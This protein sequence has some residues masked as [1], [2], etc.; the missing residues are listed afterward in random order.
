MEGSLLASWA[1]GWLCSFSW[2]ASTD[3]GVCTLG[4]PWECI[5]EH[6]PSAE[7]L[8]SYIIIATVRKL[9]TSGGWRVAKGVWACSVKV[10]VGWLSG[11]QKVS[12]NGDKVLCHSQLS[13]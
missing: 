1:T 9:G 12:G 10:S 3:F 4:L 7:T 6:G 2:W 11:H 13:C 5:Q 8:A